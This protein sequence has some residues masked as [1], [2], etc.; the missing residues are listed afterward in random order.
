TFGVWVGEL[1][2]RLSARR[3]MSIDV[4]PPQLLVAS[5]ECAPKHH[6]SQSK[7]SPQT[8]FQDATVPQ[9]VQSCDELLL[10]PIPRLYTFPCARRFTLDERIKMR[11]SKLRD[12]P[13][14]IRFDEPTA[15]FEGAQTSRC[16]PKAGLIN[17]SVA[18]SG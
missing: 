13:P 3:Q 11:S 7:G 2:G 14:F 12:E 5:Q 16:I 17:L 18:Q 4:P 8:Y 1:S 9:A 6:T 15:G 10:W